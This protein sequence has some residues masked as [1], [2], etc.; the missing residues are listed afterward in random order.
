MV[1]ELIG[2]IVG[3]VYLWLEYRASIYLWA[4]SV[5]MP[6]IYIFVYYDAGLYADFGINVYYLGAALYG[7]MIW[8]Y[9]NR[10]HNQDELPITH[11]PMPS[12]LGALVVFVVTFVAIA[13]LLIC[14]TDSNVAWCDAFTTALSII[15]MW[16]LARKYVEQWWVWM[17]VDAVCVGLYVYKDLYFTAM[18]YALY[19]IVAV[20]GWINWK[21]IMKSYGQN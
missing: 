7:W 2:T 5:V 18:L 9:G 13:W 8:R 14:Y 4:A 17:V 12:C 1:L 16:M 10:E 20:F 3:L 15:G 11:I 6:A 21:K 19:A